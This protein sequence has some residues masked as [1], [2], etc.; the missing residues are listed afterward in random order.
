MATLEKIVG[1]HLDGSL[2]IFGSESEFI[3]KIKKKTFN[4]ISSHCVTH[5]E[6]LSFTN[7]YKS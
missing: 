5:R 3:A 2:T 7:F 4:V 6:A 1:V